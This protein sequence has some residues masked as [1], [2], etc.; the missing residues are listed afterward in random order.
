VTNLTFGETEATVFVT[1]ATDAWSELYPGQ[2]YKLE[3]R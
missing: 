2:V 3:N 1:A